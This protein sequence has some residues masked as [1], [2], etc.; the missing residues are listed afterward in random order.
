[1]TLEIVRRKPSKKLGL[2]L[3]AIDGFS[4]SLGTSNR[5]VNWSEQDSSLK[6]LVEDESGLCISE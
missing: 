2:S 4:C 3:L 1:M 5:V 6:L